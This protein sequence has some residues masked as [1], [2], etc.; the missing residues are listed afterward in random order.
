MWLFVSSFLS[1]SGEQ[2]ITA[3]FSDVDKFVTKAF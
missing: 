2:N 1:S 3:I